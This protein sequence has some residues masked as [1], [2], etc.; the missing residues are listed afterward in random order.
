[1]TGSNDIKSIIKQEY[2]KCAA[3][4]IYF[5]KKYAFI[6]HPQRGRIPFQLYP[7]QEKVLKLFLRE[8]Y[9]IVLKSRQLGLST[10]VALFSL[11]LMLFNDNYNIVVICTK[12]ETAK[13][14]VNKV[15]F[16]Y[17]NLPS[18]LKQGKPDENNKLT[19][20]LI[21]N[22]Q[23]KAVSAAGDSGRSEA[24]SLL[25]VDEAAFIPNMNELW[26][27]I[28]PT[29]STGGGC[30]ALS[31]PN[32]VGNWFHEKWVKAETS[33]NKFLPIKLPWTVHPERDITWR[34]LQDID[35]GE[36]KAAQECDCVFNSSGNG[37]FNL[38]SIDFYEKNYMQPPV[39]KRGP[40]NEL[41][42]WEQPDFSKQYSVVA[43]VARG[44]G[45][46]YST[47][48]VIEM[49]TVTQVAEYKAQI[50]TKD[51]GHVLVS[52]ATEYNDAL[53]VVE[54][55]NV[56]WSVIQTIVEREYKNLYYSAKNNTEKIDVY[57]NIAYG[58]NNMVPGF[59]TSTRTRPLII[60]KFD[61]YFRDRSCIIRSKRLL[62]EMKVFIWK[63]N[64]PEAQYGYNDDLILAFAIALFVR[65]NSLKLKQQ[66]IDYTK[67]SIE[68]I[69]KNSSGFYTNNQR[70]TTDIWSWK[71][72][73]NRETEDLTWLI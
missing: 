3:D 36:R 68:A 48:H 45:T 15:K 26:A 1:M 37:V 42:V 7:F 41:W 22:S 43:D 39:E 53:L 5:A 62:E 19:F 16:M 2:I 47:F 44:D 31:T 55:A 32:G 40:T 17:E 67:A 58:D 69:S 52:I 50:P 30:I 10:L 12:T 60:S 70:K 35:L 27:S 23:I 65:D 21:N 33:E 20:K 29:I 63:N 64:K 46:D 11:W 38:N 59:T 25:I 34:E 8:K 49:E 56:G 18:W 14:M 66:G 72:G 6:A 9:D 24:V 28:Y 73:N 57:S 4:P 13:N 61:E 54:N 71:T 51:F